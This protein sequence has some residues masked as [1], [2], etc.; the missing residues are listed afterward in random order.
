MTDQDVLDISQQEQLFMED[1]LPYLLS[2][3][4]EG[5]KIR[6]SSESSVNYQ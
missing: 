6:F 5:S 2:L 1:E 4:I 3:P